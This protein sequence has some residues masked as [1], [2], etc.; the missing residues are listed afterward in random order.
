LHWGLL[1][2]SFSS[3]ALFDEKASEACSAYVDFNPIRAGIADSLIDSDYTNIKRRCEQAEKAE[4]PNDP[5]QQVKGLHPFTGNPRR[6][7]P[8]GLP[9]QLTDYLELV[10]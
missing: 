6:D 4:Q 7:M 2:R 5:Q 1:G 8:K 9:F 3:Q 10:D